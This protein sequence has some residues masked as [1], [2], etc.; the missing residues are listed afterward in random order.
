M[1]QPLCYLSFLIVRKLH[2]SAKNCDTQDS[3]DGQVGLYSSE[4]LS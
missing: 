1:S 4:V 2:K 3:P